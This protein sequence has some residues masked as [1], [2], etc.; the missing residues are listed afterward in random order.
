MPTRQDITQPKNLENE[1][2]VTTEAQ[3]VVVKMMMM[4][5]NICRDLLRIEFV[6]FKILHNNLLNIKI[7][8]KLKYRMRTTNEA[9]IWMIV[10][11]TLVLTKLLIL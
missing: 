5:E 11:T 10:T 3:I 4:M 2:Y 7:I 6:E 8:T 1:I 9:V